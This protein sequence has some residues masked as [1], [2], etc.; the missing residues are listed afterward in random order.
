MK[1]PKLIKGATLAFAGVAL[2]LGTVATPATAADF[3]GKRIEWIIP[4]G[5]GGGSNRWARFYQP[6]LQKHLPGGPTL[7]VKNMPGASTAPTLATQKKLRPTPRT[8]RIALPTHS[9]RLRRG[10]STK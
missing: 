1:T 3:S 5:T 2:T 8:M 10:S 4:Y 7:A 9:W 6:R